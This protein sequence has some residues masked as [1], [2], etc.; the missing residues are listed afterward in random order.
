MRPAPPSFADAKVVLLD[1]DDTLWENNIFFLMVEEWLRRAARSLGVSHRAMREILH[2]RELRNLQWT[3]PGYSSFE[4]SVVETIATMV[5]RTGHH[6]RHAGLSRRG[7]AWVA[8]LRRHPIILRE[9]VREALP[10][11]AGAKRVIMV[12]KGNPTDQLGKVA[13]SGLGPIVHGVEVLLHKTPAEY[14][15]LLARYGLQPHEAVMVGNSPKSDIN[16]AKA[17][18]IRTI[19]VPHPATWY[20]ELEPIRPTGPETAHVATFSGVLDVLGLTSPER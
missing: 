10:A 5:H 9:G 8:F 2:R 4:R 7:R 19:Y 18:G 1:I 17:A 16:H 6:G 15:A 12:T 11:L 20:M 13:R 3:G 14:R